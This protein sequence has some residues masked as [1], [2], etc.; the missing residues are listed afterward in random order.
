MFI[1]YPGD[2][3]AQGLKPAKTVV[4]KSFCSLS[5]KNNA[6]PRQHLSGERPM[7]HFWKASRETL[8]QTICLF[9]M[10][11]SDP[12]L[13][14]TT[15]R[16]RPGCLHQILWRCR[17]L[18]RHCNPPSLAKQPRPVSMMMAC[19]CR[20]SSRMQ[21]PEGGIFEMLMNCRMSL[22]SV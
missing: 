13:H 14:T 4:R 16:L 5:G 18:L 1:R 21:N 17:H 2:F 19:Q 8:T 22:P 11:E 3:L 6:S 9:A 12:A 20:I 10:L 7:W 15:K